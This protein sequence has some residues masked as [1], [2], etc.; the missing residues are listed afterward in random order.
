MVRVGSFSTSDFHRK[1][2]ALLEYFRNDVI[3]GCEIPTSLMGQIYPEGFLSSS[4]YLVFPLFFSRCFGTF[5][6][7][8]LNHLCSAGYLY[9]KYLLCVDTVLD[10]DVMET[11][12]N[13]VPSEVLQLRSHIYHEQSL[14]RL[15]ALFPPKSGFWASWERRNNEFL[16]SI[17]LD[18]K[19]RPD[20]ELETYIQI[21]HGKCAFLKASADSFFYRSGSK[22]PQCH[23]DITRSL[24]LLAVGRCL[25]DD[26]EDFKKDLIHNRNNYGHVLLKRWFDEQGKRFDEHSPALLEKYF[27][28]S[29][30]AEELLEM[31]KSYFNKAI[32]SVQ[33]YTHEL[34]EYIRHLEA[35]RNKSNLI[36]VNIEAYRITK[37]AQHLKGAA[38][39]KPLELNE[40]VERANNYVASM[41][42]NDGSWYEITNKQGLSNVWATGFIALNLE[43]DSAAFRKAANFLESHRQRALWGYNLDWVSDYDST[44]CALIVLMKAGSDVS[45]PMKQWLAG[46][47]DTGGFSTYTAHHKELASY[48]GFQ[49]TDL[50]KDWSRPHVCVSALAYFLLS[51]EANDVATQD[52]RVRLRSYLLEGTNPRGVWE[53]YWWSSFIYPT[54]FTIRGLMQENLLEDKTRIDVAIRYLLSRQSKDGSFKCDVLKSSSVFYT[55]LIMGM[56]CH[57]STNFNRYRVRIERMKSWLLE[58]QNENGKFESSDFIIIPMSD[59]SRLRSRRYRSNKAGGTGSITGEIA[60]L[61]STSTAYQ[62]LRQYQCRIKESQND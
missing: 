35:F 59:G 15:A 22:Y 33:A 40:A 37:L 36:K 57:Q 2:E 47:H 31:S 30:I 3:A 10:K 62:A 56:L 14:R 28:T 44:T 38:L 11:H 46:Q 29:R 5:R 61:F 4:Q 26:F 34:S 53:P 7:T 18:K 32:E 27:Y 19:Y 24:D 60:G 20:L 41:Q 43:P 51:H 25:Q 6:P 39:E 45:G 12:E 21:S 49:Q 50:L 23:A 8:E 54:V 17:L 16:Q 9:F 13:A 55:A 58:R 52:A 1:K 48:M 42:N